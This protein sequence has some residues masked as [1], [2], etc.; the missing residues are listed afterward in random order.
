M[1]CIVTGATGFI[2]SHLTEFLSNNGSEVI[3]P[4]RNINRLRYL[5]SIEARVIT[6]ENLEY[7]LAKN[8]KLDYVFHLAGATRALDYAGYRA[9]NVD[10]TKYFL[11]LILNKVDLKFFKR[12]VFVSSQAVSGPASSPD[13]FITEQDPPNPISLY[14]RSKMEAETIVRQYGVHIPYVIIRPSTVFGPYDIDVLGVFKSCKYRIA[15]CLT[16]KNR[17][18]SVIF[19]KDLVRGI[20]TAAFSE[21]STRGTYFITDPEPVV[22]RDF[23]REIAN[24]M[25]VRVFILPIP[26]FILR[27]LGLGADILGKFSGKPFLFR[28]EKI[29]EMDQWFWVCSSERARIDFGWAPQ[30]SLRDNLQKTFDWYKK[31][32][33]L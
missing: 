11:D 9:A 2:G 3:C 28:T 24:V 8:N 4:V 21:H 12:F 10:L 26:G 27:F 6:F 13:S 20:K 22:W 32:G 30:N 23:I 31:E 29:D 16:G 19:V 25:G 18:V 5:K 15:P 33:W 1:R 14:G 7:E 17:K